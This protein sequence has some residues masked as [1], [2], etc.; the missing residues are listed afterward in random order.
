MPNDALT[1]PT[2]EAA[3]ASPAGETRA[4]KGEKPIRLTAPE[5]APPKP[6][7]SGGIRRLIAIAVIGAAVIGGATYWWLNRGLVSTDDAFI[8]GN[9][10][11]LSPQVGG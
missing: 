10:V 7:K 11:T 5:Q 1:K 8:D 3:P 4:L 6:K 2:A 9:T